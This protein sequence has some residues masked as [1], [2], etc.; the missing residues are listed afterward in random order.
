[1][2]TKSIRIENAVNGM[3]YA[4]YDGG[5]QL[6]AYLQGM[7]THYNELDSRIESYLASR[8]PQTTAQRTVARNSKKKETVD[9]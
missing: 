6:P 5:G 8:K 7:W 1:M 4:K 9:G 3:F 2:T